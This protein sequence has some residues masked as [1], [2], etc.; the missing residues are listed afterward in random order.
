M[1]SKTIRNADDYDF[2]INHPLVRYLRGKLF[3]VTTLS[4]Y[5][6]IKRDGFL[7][8]ND[9]SLIGV[10][11][12]KAPRLTVCEKLDAISLF[13]F[14]QSDERMF[15][16]LQ[17]TERVDEYF[18]EWGQFLWWYK[19]TTIILVLNRGLVAPNLLTYE[20]CKTVQGQWIYNVEVCHR[21]PIPVSAIEESISVQ[22]EDECKGSFAVYPQTTFK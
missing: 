12:R 21:G 22:A 8:P 18:L 5:R 10:Y 19:P 20:E 11:K 4:N 7:K 14:N 6:A 17:V 9:G 13:D 15:P 1:E 3:H 16:L 2:L